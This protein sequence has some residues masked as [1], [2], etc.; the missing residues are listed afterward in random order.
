[1][2]CLCYFAIIYLFSFNAYSIWFP[3]IHSVQNYNRLVI[4]FAIPEFVTQ[5]FLI[6]LPVREAGNIA[7]VNSI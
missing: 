3:K 5:F 1:M 4:F 6:F 2:Y 7:G